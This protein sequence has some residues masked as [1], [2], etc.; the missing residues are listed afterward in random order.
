MVGP[1]RSRRASGRVPVALIA[2]LALWLVVPMMPFG[3]GSEVL[4]ADPAATVIARYRTRI[5]ELMA[6]Q[7]LPGLAVALVDADEALWVEGFGYTNE[8]GFSQVTVDTIFSVQSIS[9]TF[10]ATA[11]MIAVQEGLLDLDEPLL[12][13]CRTSPSTAHSRSTPSGRSP[14]GCS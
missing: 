4:A 12:R 1:R 3:Q 5:P 8:Q 7:D 11:V 9:K 2:A 13:T 10:T 14:S 6:A